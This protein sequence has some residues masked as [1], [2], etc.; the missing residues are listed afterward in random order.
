M[1]IHPSPGNQSLLLSLHRGEKEVEE[2]G[3]QAETLAVCSPPP[4][5]S[6]RPVVV[7]A[8]ALNRLCSSCIPNWRLPDTLSTV[9]QVWLQSTALLF[10]LLGDSGFL[11]VC[12][13]HGVEAGLK[14]SIPHPVKWQRQDWSPGRGDSMKLSRQMKITRALDSYGARFESCLLPARHCMLSSLCTTGSSPRLRMMISAS[15]GD[16][17]VRGGMELPR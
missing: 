6:H 15:L 4:L 9:S 7:K 11:A 14:A 12:E 17:G 8:D 3:K 16:S 1:T 5:R 10:L 13:G 2:G